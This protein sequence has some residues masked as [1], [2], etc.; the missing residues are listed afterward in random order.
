VRR[1]QQKWTV[2]APGQDLSAKVIQH[3]DQVI[4]SPVLDQQIGYEGK[5]ILQTA[6]FD[7]TEH[8]IVL[9]YLLYAA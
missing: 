8:D 1:L 7:N 6:R 5:F 4:A 9:N 2:G 3:R